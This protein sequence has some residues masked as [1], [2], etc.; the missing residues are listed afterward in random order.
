MPSDTPTPPKEK[1]TLSDAEFFGVKALPKSVVNDASDKP[2]WYQDWLSDRRLYQDFT[3]WYDAWPAV[4]LFFSLHT[5]W[6]HGFDGVTGLDYTAVLSVIALHVS[7]RTEQL[8]LLTEI[9]AL[10]LGAMTAIN[11][12]R[13]K[14]K[15]EAEQKQKSKS[16]GR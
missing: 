8:E 13:A 4:Q 1:K 11:E 6:R 15:A 2:D 12:Q 3:V 14:A 7:R 16:H 10:E 9:Q 5:Q